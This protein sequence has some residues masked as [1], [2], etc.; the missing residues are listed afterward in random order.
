[1]AENPGCWCE[2]KTTMSEFLSADEL[3]GVCEG[4]SAVLLLGNLEFE[5]SVDLPFRT[6]A[7]DSQVTDPY[8]W[9]SKVS[10]ASGIEIYSTIATCR[11]LFA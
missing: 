5:S 3:E 7:T 6:V 10:G 1:M 2:I 11:S 9:V 8:Y 4:L